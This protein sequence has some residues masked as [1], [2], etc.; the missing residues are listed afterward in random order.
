M[1]SNT[2]LCKFEKS[3][4][5]D[6]KKFLPHVQFVRAGQ[7]TVAFAHVGNLVEFST[8]ICADNEKKNR[9]KVGKYWA[10]TRFENGQTV[11]MRF[12]D[13]D[14]MIDTIVTDDSYFE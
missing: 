6:M 4:F 13:F 8:A 9:P 5:K 14:N 2:K 1:Q 3:V 12:A 11:K 7:T 10:M